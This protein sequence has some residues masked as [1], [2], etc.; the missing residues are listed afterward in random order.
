MEVAIN[1]PNIVKLMREIR[2]QFSLDIMDMS[3]EEQKTYIKKML[4][5]QKEKRKN[6]LSKSNNEE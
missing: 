2:N 4:K 5:E 1:K 6:K 3:F